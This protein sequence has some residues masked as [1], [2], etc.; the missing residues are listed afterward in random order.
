M[1][2][3]PPLANSAA[4]ATR[5]AAG[6]PSSAASRSA[7][8]PAPAPAAA[9][10]HDTL[11]PAEAAAVSEFFAKLSAAAA[12]K[13]DKR[14]PLKLSTIVNDSR[15]FF[16]RSSSTL[17]QLADQYLAEH[18]DAQAYVY[19]LKV[20]NALIIEELPK[21]P[22]YP[23]KDV[24]TIT[25]IKRL[26]EN[27]SR[28]MD[29]MARIR[30]GLKQRVIERE[31]KRQAEVVRQLQAEALK[32]RDAAEDE[33]DVVAA[34]SALSLLETFVPQTEAPS[35]TFSDPPRRLAT[36]E[37]LSPS[38]DPYPTLGNNSSEGLDYRPT[39]VAPPKPPTSSTPLPGSLQFP[40]SYQPPAS[41]NPY[42]NTGPKAP[43]PYQPP[44]SSLHPSQSAYVPQYRQPAAPLRTAFQTPQPVRP[45]PA[46]PP[47]VPGLS[48]SPPP[49]PSPP[50]AAP[51]GSAPPIPWKPSLASK[52]MSIDTNAYP[53]GKPIT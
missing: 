4:A 44:P 37:A 8:A 18:D 7:P 43:S 35:S 31:R 10:P 45:P 20:M 22:E 12:V 16:Y 50:T 14:R 15:H 28:A 1:P 2:P 46:I 34:V 17:L 40:S 52:V 5:R 23:S 26:R 25:A 42:V 27:C 53:Q 21:H 33:D 38:K 39:P 3:K 11:P 48:T 36:Y 49:L 9:D 51:S 41:F 47:K 29:S 19:F 30:P 13:I 24:A 32:Q 6:A